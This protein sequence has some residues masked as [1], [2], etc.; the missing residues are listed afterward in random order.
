VHRF[1]IV[2]WH[3]LLFV[4]VLDLVLYLLPFSPLGGAP[5]YA[6]ISRML[7]IAFAGAPVFFAVLGAISLANQGNLWG[8]LPGGPP[9]ALREFARKYP[10]LRA[11]TLGFGA[12]PSPSPTGPRA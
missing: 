6:M 7:A 10:H 1:A 9:F 3:C 12:L 11:E 8:Y 4:L 2:F 5:L